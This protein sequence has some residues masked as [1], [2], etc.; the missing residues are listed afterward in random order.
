MSFQVEAGSAG[1]A[2]AG[3]LSEIECVSVLLL[4]AGR[5]PP[6]INDVPVLARNFWFTDL[7][8]QY[9]TVAQKTTGFGLVDNKVIWPSGKGLGGS[10]LLKGMMYVRGNRKNYDD[11]EK[12]G[13]KGWGYS[14]VFPY[15]LK[16]EENRDPEYYNNGY[17][18]RGGPVTFHKP[19]Y[20]AE[21]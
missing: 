4:E 8:W 9:K 14:D 13:A 18:A 2:V 12:Q 15:F 19:R 20:A 5:S 3:R 16:L 17:H 7:D 21:I 6:I 10:S 1:A 11:W